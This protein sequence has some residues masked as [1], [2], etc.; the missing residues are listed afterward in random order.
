[1]RHQ[2]LVMCRND[3]KTTSAIICTAIEATSKELRIALEEY[4]LAKRGG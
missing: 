3:R 2:V 4:Y 1:L